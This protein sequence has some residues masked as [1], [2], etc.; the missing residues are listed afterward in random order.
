VRIVIW[1]DSVSVCVSGDGKSLRLKNASL[2]HDGRRTQAKADDVTCPC[3]LGSRRARRAAKHVE[4]ERARDFY[5]HMDICLHLLPRT[6]LWLSVWRRV[7]G[8][9]LEAANVFSAWIW[10][11]KSSSILPLNFQYVVLYTTSI[12]L[13]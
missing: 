12:N 1:I 8:A 11:E 2:P 4:P 6:Q 5:A 10:R 7:L 9:S 13:R 3:A